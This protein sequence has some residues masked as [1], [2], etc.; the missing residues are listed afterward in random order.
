[1]NTRKQKNNEHWA[2][3]LE[4]IGGK[5]C[6]GSRVLRSRNRKIEKRKRQQ[7]RSAKP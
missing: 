1:M 5:N 6:D 2:V 7:F 4:G 3:I